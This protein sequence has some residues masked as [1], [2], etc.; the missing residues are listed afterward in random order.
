MSSHSHDVTQIEIDA[1]PP[2]MYVFDVDS[3]AQRP[4]MEVAIDRASR[5][6]IWMRLHFGE[7]P[8]SEEVRLRCA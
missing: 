5:Q 6:I 4:I 7:A 2:D 1:I 3:R 8:K